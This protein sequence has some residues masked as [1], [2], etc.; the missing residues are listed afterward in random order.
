MV[1]DKQNR[2]SVAAEFDANIEV[3]RS[4]LRDDDDVLQ[5]YRSVLTALPDEWSSAEIRNRLK[6]S[7]HP[8]ALPTSAFDD[9]DSLVQDH[10]DSE[11]WE[12]HE[13]VNDW[14]RDVLL[15]VPMLAVD[16]S[17]IPPTTQFNLPVAYVQAAWA[18]NHHVPEGEFDR[19]LSGQ[20][21]TPED[22]CRTNAGYQFVDSGLVGEHR[23]EHE[24][25]MVIDQMRSLSEA[26]ESGRL[27]RPPVVLYDG[28]LVISFVEAF[29]KPRR[30]HY[31]DVMSRIL[32]ASEHFEIPLVGY[33]AGTAARELTT[34]V[35]KL[36]PDEFRGVEPLEDGRVLSGLMSPWGDYTTPFV[37]RRDESVDALNCQYNGKEYDFSSD[38][39][40]SYLNVP[41]GGGLDRLEFPGWLTRCEG[42]AGYETMYDYTL[43][44]VRAEA[45][46]GRGYPELLQQVDSDAVLDQRDRQQFLKLLQNWAD[47]NDIPLE[48]DAKALSKELRRR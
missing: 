13:A 32:A 38:L 28:P 18:L 16:G 20:L 21:L 14:A 48:W 15:D 42:P 36:L 34:T 45:A 6:D 23:Y 7:P 27:E 44:M 1:F 37:S 33:V 47:E 30:Q 19:G 3:I 26:R 25:E 31:L 39:L 5:R 9:A 35:R 29:G 12:S 10:S 4:Y 41:P 22:V 46:V 17:E 11:Q 40:F 2:R 8:G 43:E 24:G